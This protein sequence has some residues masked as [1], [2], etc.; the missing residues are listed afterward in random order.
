MTTRPRL[1]RS[2]P[3]WGLIAGSAAAVGFGAWLTID[4]ISIMTST[5][6]DGSATGVEVYAGQAWALF[7]AVIAG[8]GLV[9][10]VAA[11]ALSAAR[12]LVT[13]KVD[14]VE[15]ITWQD[16]AEPLAA[17]TA[18]DIAAVPA[19]TASAPQN[20]VEETIEK[21]ITR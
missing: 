12:S 4:K 16:E 8:A 19:D 7:G 3:F 20:D 14:V 1:S 9:G 17:E 5:L 6:T 13:P 2:I 10:L 15:T 21:P 11:L 18:S